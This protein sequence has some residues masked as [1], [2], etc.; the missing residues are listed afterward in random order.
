MT[1]LVWRAAF[2]AVEKGSKPLW[3]A[4]VDLMQFIRLTV[5]WGAAWAGSAM[6]KREIVTLH[7]HQIMDVSEWSRRESVKLSPV[8]G[9]VGS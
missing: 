3:S 8:M 4:Y 5:L 9:K 2:Q 1:L 6:R 7:F